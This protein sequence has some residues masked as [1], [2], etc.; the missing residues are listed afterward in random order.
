MIETV[1]EWDAVLVFPRESGGERRNGKLYSKD[2]FVTLMLGLKT[3]KDPDTKKKKEF[4]DQAASILRTDRCF[5]DEAGK[6]NDELASIAAEIT[7]KPLE[8]AALEDQ[9]TEKKKAMLNAEYKKFTGTDEPILQ[10]QFCELVARSICKRVQDACGLE[11]AMKL[12]VDQDEII[13]CIRADFG[14]LATEADRTNYQMQV[15]LTPFAPGRTDVSAADVRAMEGYAESVALLQRTCDEAAVPQLDPGMHS[16]RWHQRLVKQMG[17]AGHA[18]AH[19]CGA[20]PPGEL[21]DV[22]GANNRDGGGVYLSPYTDYKMEPKYQP[23]FRHYTRMTDQG[24]ASSVFRQID[25]TRLVNS[26]LARHLNIPV[27]TYTKLLTVSFALH[28]VRELAF[29]REQWVAPPRGLKSWACL[30]LDRPQPLL[31]IRDYFGEKVAIYFAWL[32]Q[33]TRALILPAII[34]VVFQASGGDGLALLAFGGFVSIWATTQTEVWKRRNAFLNLWWGMS[35]FQTTEAERPAF[36]GTVRRSPV[37]DRPETQHIS[38]RKLNERIASSMILIFFCILIVISATGGCILLKVYLMD[39]GLTVGPLDG[40]A[41]AGIANAF[42]INILNVV[43]TGIARDL[44]NWENHRTNT[45][46]ENQLIVKTFLFRFFNSY[47]S[48]FYIAFIR[49]WFDPKGCMD[50]NQKTGI[51]EG[52]PGYVRKAEWCMQELSAQLL[53]IFLTQI[54]VGNTMELLVPAIKMKLKLRAEAKSAD[55]VDDDGDGI[56]DDINYEQPELEAKFEKYEEKEAFD[57]YAEMVVQFGFVTLFVVAFPLTPLLALINNAIEVH[58][59]AAKLCFSRKK[60]PPS[61]GDSIGMWA[62][63][64]GVLSKVSVVTNTLIICFTSPFSVDRGWTLGTQWL[65]FVVAEHVMLVV[66]SV[67]EDAVPDAAPFVLTLQARFQHLT[68]KLFLEL[69]ADDDDGLSEQAEKV[70]TTIHPNGF[71]FGRTVTVANP[72]HGAGAMAKK[73]PITV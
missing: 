8:A 2:R 26:L 38:V 28:D 41:L 62:Y 51:L 18:D 46:Y 55:A 42:Q 9:R 63:F 17:K 24:P 39:I 5:L 6:P 36:F 12:S 29:L 3:I 23:F 68:G 72:M 19:Q 45:A 7:E 22:D 61:G 40:K 57:D 37:T 15:H 13:C 70:D 31:R 43:Y 34:G 67:V 56:P 73:Q 71:Q 58:V 69:A 20:A 54:V 1:Y 44:N 10:V 14:D 4:L 32:D 50:P 60:P 64:I 52:A 59:D 47:A 27:L 35:D 53:T 11:C 21:A 66:K 65:C 25:R 16:S 49:S 30:G 33:Y 48:F